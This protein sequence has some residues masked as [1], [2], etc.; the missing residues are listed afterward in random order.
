MKNVVKVLG[1]IAIV[2][3]IGFGFVSCDDGNKGGGGDVTFNVTNNYTSKAVSVTIT[4]QADNAETTK[5]LSIAG[6]GG[7]G[8]FKVKLTKVIT[9]DYMGQLEF[10]FED[11]TTG[12]PDGTSHSFDGSGSTFNVTIKANGKHDTAKN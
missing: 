8:S 4:N 7:T 1:I 10:K 6:S 12:G 9:G 2:A 11:T 3:V 5:D